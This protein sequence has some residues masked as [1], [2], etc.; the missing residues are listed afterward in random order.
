M[1]LKKKK[2]GQEKAVPGSLQ[3]R[4]EGRLVGQALTMDPVGE[5]LMAPVTN[6]RDS[7]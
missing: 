6:E 2:K 3:R 5:A 7:A 4:A 1:E